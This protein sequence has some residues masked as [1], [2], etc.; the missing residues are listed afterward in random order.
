VEVKIE[1]K[2]TMLLTVTSVLLISML[3]S[4]GIAAASNVYYPDL[5]IRGQGVNWVIPTDIDL[6]RTPDFNGKLL[7]EDSV[8]ATVFVDT[9]GDSLIDATVVV[10]PNNIVATENFIMLVFNPHSLPDGKAIKT[11]VTGNLQGDDS[12]VATGPGFTYRIK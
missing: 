1:M 3:A 2:R 9:N 5:Q 10:T 6:D 7:I 12:L 4:I 8:V 11:L